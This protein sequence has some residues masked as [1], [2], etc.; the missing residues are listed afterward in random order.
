MKIVL[1][2]VLMFLV[3]ILAACSGAPAVESSPPTPASTVK[4]T[5]APTEPPPATSV[6]TATAMAAVTRP[7]SEYILLLPREAA[8]PADWVMNPQPAYESRHP[9]PGDTYRFGCQELTSRAIGQARVGYRHLEGMPNVNIEYVIYPTADLAAAA[10][11]DMESAVAACP[12]F[13]IGQGNGAV[14]AAFTPLEFPVYGDGSF[15]AALITEGGATGSLLTHMI[16]VRSGHVVIGINHA[17]Y[18]G[19]EPPDAALTESLVALAA[20]NMADGPAAPGE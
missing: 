12:T 4:T 2:N 19:A 3:V 17:N 16:K 1:S 6:P 18:A 5:L 15:G 8:V 9:Q 13:T 11:A 14:A 20:G 10:L 7:G